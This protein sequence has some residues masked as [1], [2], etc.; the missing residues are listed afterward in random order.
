MHD[1]VVKCEV[2]HNIINVHLNHLTLI[3]LQH[4]TRIFSKV[5][6]LLADINSHS[7]LMC[8]FVCTDLSPT[9][10]RLPAT[11]RFGSESYFY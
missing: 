10:S 11:L 8:L 5:I 3:Q 4:F 9:K 7:I 2:K 1:R 6:N